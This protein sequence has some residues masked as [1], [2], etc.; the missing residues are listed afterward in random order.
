M[1]LNVKTLIIAGGVVAAMALEAV[2][3][4]ILMPSPAPQAA[5]ETATPAEETP[6]KMTESET[7]EEPIGEQFN[8][9][10]NR[11]ES[12]VHLRF[13][14]MAVVKSGQEVPFREMN[15]A[16]KARIRQAIEKIARNA[17]REDF[18]DPSLNT[19]RRLIREE[20]NKVLGKSF[21]M[22]SVIYDFSMIEQ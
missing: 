9:T 21:V 14:V 5:A 20:V 13:K 12:I 10:N 11:E 19:L 8:C 22:D 3:F 16:Y 15:T 18:D 17:T 2:V 4:L 6:E 1:K 7:K